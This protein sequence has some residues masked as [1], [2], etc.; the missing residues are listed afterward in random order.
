MRN[1]NID[2]PDMEQLERYLGVETKPKK[3]EKV[4]KAAVEAERERYE[5]SKRGRRTFIGTVSVLVVIAAIAVLISMLW[6]P[7]LRIYGTSMSPT[8]SEGE[9]VVAVKGLS[10]N[11]GDI[12][13]CYSGN[14]LL[15][16]RV[17]AKPGQYVSID[18]NGNIFVDGQLLEE[19][20]LT[21]K[22][23]GECDLEFPYQVPDGKWF[24]VGDHRESSI[25]SRSSA[26]GCIAKD[27]LV[28]M[29]ILRVWPLQQIKIFK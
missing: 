9:I 18:D 3:P 26:V 19:D 11:T 23:L 20:Y 13:A 16:K 10:L 17:I 6:M 4:S 2:I 15:V 12:A 29:V 22:A 28:G 27:D 25:D 5:K 21:E 14:K 24:V 8:L 1:R 7:V